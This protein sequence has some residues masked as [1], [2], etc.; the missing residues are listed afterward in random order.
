M[1]RPPLWTASP[2]TGSTMA[3]DFG[4]PGT[5]RPRLVPPR[6]RRARLE[7]TSGPSW[8]GHAEEAVPQVI[9]RQRIQGKRGIFR[10]LV[11]FGCHRLR[12]LRHRLGLVRRVLGIVDQVLKLIDL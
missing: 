10:T 4:P 7:T 5:R 11:C 9:E 8:T 2:R 12:V 1:V 6:R 3:V